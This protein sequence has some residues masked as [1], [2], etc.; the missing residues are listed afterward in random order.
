MKFCFGIAFICFACSALEAETSPDALHILATAP[1]RFEPAP[2][3]GPAPFVA[4]GLRFRY[5]FAPSQAT[6]HARG[7][8]VRLQFEG[9][10]S[11]ASI[12]GDEKLASKTNYYLGNDRSKWRTSVPNFGRL[13]VHNLYPGIDLVY[14][15]RPSELEY[16]LSVKPGADPSSIRLRLTGS[17]AQLDRKGNLISELIQKRPVA[18]QIGQDGKRIA[19]ASRYRRNADGTYG[20]TLGRYDHGRDLVI[21]PVLTTAV[22]VAGSEQ[23]IAYGIGHDSNGLLYISGTTLSTDFQPAG[24]PDQP[25]AGGG[26]DLFLT[27]INPV[28]SALYYSSYIGGSLDET[29]G[30]MSVGPHGDVYLTGATASAD[31]PTANPYQSVPATP[32]TSTTSTTTPP[33]PV[34]AFIAWFDGSQTLRY[35]TFIGGTG[36]LDIGLAIAADS[37]G[38]LWVTG[39]TDSADFPQLNPMQIYG[40]MQ[41]MFVVGIDPSQSGAATLIY[42]S[43]L[44]GTGWDIGHSIAVAP[45]GTLWIAAGT[46][47]FDI[48]IVGPCFQCS[49]Q[50]GGDGYV[51]Q[52]N[53]TLSGANALVFATYL[54][55]SNLEEAKSIVLDPAGRIIVSGYTLSSNFPV[56]ANALQ[57]QFGGATD[58]FVTVLDLSKTPSSATLAY[59]TYF[60][61]SDVDVPFDMK[62]DANGFV[63]L[64]GYTLSYGLPASANALQTQ[65]DGTMDAFA[66]KLALPTEVA[67]A[68]RNNAISYFTYL[69]SDGLQ[70]GYGIDFDNQGN[71]YLDGFT[72]GPIFDPFGGPSKTTSAGN[73]DVFVAG[74]SPTASLSTSDR[75]K[76]VPEREASLTGR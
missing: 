45:D 75:E 22:Y 41:D 69:G 67:P 15:G 26:F 17:R 9:A 73:V 57:P 6:L 37:Q 65:F 19:V 39:D 31:F 38:R 10:T 56:T 23:D 72:S 21:D 76:R 7:K 27:V 54:G 50:G 51:A 61:G 12:H 47:S 60:G 4:R 48:N 24:T 43:F 28:N 66:L 8:S 74:F 49:Y 32:P 11:G 14:Y 16:D 46:S 63:Y 2:Q 20:F 53:P 62:Q 55:G 33:T 64:S 3:N 35:S 42:S 68:G 71:I 29:F 59:S 52:V 13:S 70:I 30:G 25:I 40:G 44:G 18:Y 58:A 34:N 1:L 5:D 36:T